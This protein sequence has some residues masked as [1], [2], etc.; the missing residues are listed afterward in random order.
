VEALRNVSWNKGGRMLVWRSAF[1][2]G[3]VFIL[4]LN[5]GESYIPIITEVN[6]AENVEFVYKI[7]L[8]HPPEKDSQ[9]S[10]LDTKSGY[11]HLSTEDQ[12]P[13]TA[14]LFFNKQQTLWL[15][16]ISFESIKSRSKWDKASNGLYYPH[17]YDD[18]LAN[19]LP[20]G[21]G[22][23]EWIRDENET[24]TEAI[25]KLKALMSQ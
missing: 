24:W 3:A 13:I 10:E 22:I 25:P 18:D 17:L 1:W 7:Y 5:F 15:R 2:C 14:N 20:A 9:L 6:M 11:I 23:L 4:K 21:V 19:A 12:I 8:E 16:K